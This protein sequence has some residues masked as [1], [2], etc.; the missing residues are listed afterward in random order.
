VNRDGQTAIERQILSQD[1]L[2]SRFQFVRDHK[3]AWGVKRPAR[4]L[5]S[6]VLVLRLAS[7]RPEAGGTSLGRR[8]PDP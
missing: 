7:Q 4:S 6:P 8:S 5:E 1:E 2:V 3:E